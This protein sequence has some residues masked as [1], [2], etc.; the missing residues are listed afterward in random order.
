[1]QTVLETDV[2]SL[3]A[4]LRADAEAAVRDVTAAAKGGRRCYVESEDDHF[5]FHNFRRTA[6]GQPRRIIL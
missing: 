6:T 3:T 4:Q 1:M 5:V 2:F